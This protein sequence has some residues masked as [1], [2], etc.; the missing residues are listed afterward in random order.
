MF[1]ELIF[2]GECAAC[3][4][5]AQWMKAREPWLAVHSIHSAHANLTLRRHFPNGWPLRPYI[6]RDTPQ[7]EEAI[8]GMRLAFVVLRRFGP[9]GAVK[10]I[11]AWL[12]RR[13]R[14]RH[15][16]SWMTAPEHKLRAYS[17]ESVAVA[18]QFAAVQLMVPTG[19]A[20]RRIVQFYN[21]SGPVQ[22]ASYWSVDDTT[23]LVV[24]Q[25]HAALPPPAA[26][27]GTISDRV[28]VGGCPAHYYTAPGPPGELT[29]HMLIIPGDNGRWLAVRGNNMTRR[30]LMLAAASIDLQRWSTNAF[31]TTPR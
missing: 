6:I 10:A 31:S 27:A 24:E 13:R 9:R 29:G 16:Q 15:Q 11:S 14:D 3:S 20:L 30:D 17:A 8:C 19:L 12:A 18:E 2:D 21:A 4:S 5:L 1:R 28:S 25:T 26:S 23:M 7:G 22:T